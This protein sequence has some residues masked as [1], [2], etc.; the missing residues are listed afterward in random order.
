MKRF[1]CLP[2]ALGLALICSPAFADVADMG[3][4]AHT[5][6]QFTADYKSDPFA[7]DVYFSWAEGFMSGLNKQT[8]LDM[9]QSRDVA[10]RTTGS[11]ER[12]LRDYCDQHPSDNY[13]Q[14]VLSLYFSFKKPVSI[15]QNSN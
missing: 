4:G 3:Q 14:A 6:A 9:G 10:T 13:A 12:S 5:C 1:A 11:K 8:L 2:V 15:S 7:E